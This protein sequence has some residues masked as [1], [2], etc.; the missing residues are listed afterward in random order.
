MEALRLMTLTL[1]LTDERSVQIVLLEV[2]FIPSVHV[3]RCFAFDETDA[4][5]VVIGSEK[6]W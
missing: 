2:T 6:K 1:S 4:L 3:N 5:R